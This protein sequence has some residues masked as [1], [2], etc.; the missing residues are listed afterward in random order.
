MGIGPVTYLVADLSPGLQGFGG[1]FLALFCDPASPNV[2]ALNLG[3]SSIVD[4]LRGVSVARS[5]VDASLHGVPGDGTVVALGDLVS[6]SS[7]S[8]SMVLMPK[9]TVAVSANTAGPI[10]FR[11]FFLASAVWVAV[12]VAVA[13]G[14]HLARHLP[15]APRHKRSDLG[16]ALLVAGASSSLPTDE[17]EMYSSMCFCGAACTSTVARTL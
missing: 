6:S 1:G 11:F 17:S 15:R 12:I 7:S 8:P 5:S 14:G 9:L 13:R 2:L 16:G 3:R 4:V 10:L